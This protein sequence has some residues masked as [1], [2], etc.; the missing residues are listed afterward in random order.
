MMMAVMMVGSVCVGL[1]G[2]RLTMMLRT[3]TTGPI[4][5]ALSVVGARAPTLMPKAEAEMP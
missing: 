4:A 2:R 3:M 1:S 5:R